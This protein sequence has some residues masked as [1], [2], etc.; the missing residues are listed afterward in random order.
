MSKDEK[1]IKRMKSVANDLDNPVYVLMGFIDPYEVWADF[2]KAYEK[3]SDDEEIS[4]AIME[5][6]GSN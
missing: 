3:Y 1:E 4:M 2:E 5:L 6:K